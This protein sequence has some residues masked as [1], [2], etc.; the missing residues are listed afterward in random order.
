MKLN[1]VDP[2][3]LFIDRWAV[4]TAGS[5]EKFNGMTVS[6]GSLGTIWR[7]PAA[8]V[9]VRHSRYT[10]EILDNT[11]TYT[12]S[13]F[14]EK[15]KDALTIMGRNSGR[16]TDKI[17]MAGLTPEF[18]PDGK[19]VT[20]KEAELVLVLKKRFAQDMATDCM[21]PEIAEEFYSNH[22]DHTIYIGEIIDI[23]EK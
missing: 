13:F 6:W 9:Y 1:N 19:G 16:D 22:D 7:N 5:Q 18:L 15:Y 14:P 8:T 4:L 23:I 11:D 3:S 12:L 10:H 21:K 20:Y 2:L 17:S